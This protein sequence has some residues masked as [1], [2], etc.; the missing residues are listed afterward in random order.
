MV[1]VEVELVE[2]LDDVDVVTPPL[3]ITPPVEVEELPVPVELSVVVVVDPVAEPQVPPRRPNA[4]E[5][6][7]PRPSV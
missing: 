4:R 3:L 6:W 5:T 1:F 2:E 7:L